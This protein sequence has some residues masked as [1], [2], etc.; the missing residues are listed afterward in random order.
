[1][2]I[3]WFFKFIQLTNEEFEKLKDVQIVTRSNIGQMQ[4]FSADNDDIAELSESLNG[5]SYQL[6]EINGK[7]SIMFS[8]KNVLRG[9]SMEDFNLTPS[10]Q[11]RFSL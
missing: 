5:H 8:A 1:M 7:E 3:P 6:R 10:V 4:P 9:S 2:L 11:S